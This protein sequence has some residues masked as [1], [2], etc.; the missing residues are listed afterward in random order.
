YV[1]TRAATAD[2]R[3]I[4]DYTRANWGPA[5]AARYLA[6]IRD[7]C[8]APAEGRRVHRP[9]EGRPGMLKAAVGSHIVFFRQAEDATLVIVRIL[10]QRMNAPRNLRPMDPD[11][12]A[13][14]R[15][16]H[17]RTRS[18]GRAGRAPRRDGPR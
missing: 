17:A 18:E 2:L 13:Q 9:C 15:N 12:P 1:L 4:R 8:A 16:A 5:Q 7:T 10:H 3:E 11:P 14:P 6:G